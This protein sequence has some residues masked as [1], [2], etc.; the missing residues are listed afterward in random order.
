MCFG[1]NGTDFTAY[2]SVPS[3]LI[4]ISRAEKTKGEE[5]ANP[6]SIAA[7]AQHD[8]LVHSMTA[9]FMRPLLKVTNITLA[10]SQSPYLSWSF[11]LSD[12]IFRGEKCPTSLH[13]QITHQTASR[14]HVLSFLFLLNSFA[15]YCISSLSTSILLGMSTVSKVH[16]PCWTVF[17]YLRI[18]RKVICF[19]RFDCRTLTDPSGIQ[20]WSHDRRN[21]DKTKQNWNTS[22]RKIRNWESRT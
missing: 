10:E 4:K 12:N 2:S 20:P 18:P 16:N 6:T 14:C 5:N 9:C 15:S 1:S 22:W 21:Q 13:R 11:V 7:F 8:V 17:R 19:I 3:R